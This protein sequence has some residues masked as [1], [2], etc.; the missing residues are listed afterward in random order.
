[1]ADADVTVVGAGIVGL[2]TACALQRRHPGLAVVVVDKE[3]RVAAHQSG[4]NSGVLHSGLYYRPGSLKARLAVA[5]RAAMVRFCAEHGVAHEVCG[6]VVVAVDEDERPRLEALAERAKANGVRATLVSA[7]GLAGLEPHARGVAALHVPDAGIADFAR[8]CLALAGLVVEAGGEV[9]LSTPVEAVVESAG[10]VTVETGRGRLT[11]RWAVNCAGL[12]A[13]R[14]AGPVAAGAGVRLVPFRGEFFD[15]VPERRHLVRNLLY[16]VPDPA[17]PFLGVHLTRSIDGRAHAG[18]NA[19]PALAREGY[20]WRDVEPAELAELV[21]DAG[22]RRLARLHWRTGAGEVVR[23]LSRN[24]FVRALQRLVPDLRREDL[25]R[26]PAG[27]RALAVRPDGTI[28]DDFVLAGE[29]RVVHVLNA[30]SPA[31]TASLLIGE[32]VADRLDEVAGR[33]A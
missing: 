24:A 8:V 26:A 1:M 27:V 33:G 5:G 17:F 31:A 7:A 14:L 6:K 15:L 4:R 11:S 16:P 12:H 32:A 22:L 20:R 13:D 28:V 29:G 18:P 10:G 25:V 3:D 30:P 23:S 21:R 2:A 19:V 9:R